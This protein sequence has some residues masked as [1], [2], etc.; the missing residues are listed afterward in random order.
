MSTYQKLYNFPLPQEVTEVN[1][2]YVFIGKCQIYNS[3]F[4]YLRTNFEGKVVNY[5]F[6]EKLQP[7]PFILINQLPV[8]V[9][10]DQNLLADALNLMKLLVEQ[11]NDVFLLLL[12]PN[13]KPTFS[14]LVPED[15]F[16]LETEYFNS[17]STYDLYHRKQTSGVV[18]S[19]IKLL[20]QKV[21]KEAMY[22]ELGLSYSNFTFLLLSTLEKL[23]YGLGVFTPNFSMFR[24]AF[25]QSNVFHVFDYLK[26]HLDVDYLLAFYNN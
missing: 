2:S 21:S 7:A 13:L 22:Q 18:D 23:L 24:S 14:N 6:P 10:K 12:D 25:R 11:E 8:I 16:Y 5:I 26:N 19:I 17:E 4:R 9:I 1:K 20:K 15:V 3:F